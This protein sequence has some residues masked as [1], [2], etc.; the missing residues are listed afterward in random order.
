MLR[1]QH[2]EY[3]LLAF[4][5][6][7][8]EIDKTNQIVELIRSA[9]SVALMPSKTAGVDA[10]AAAGGLYHMLREEG[11]DV[12]VIYPGLPPEEYG[13]VEDLNISPNS[14]KGSL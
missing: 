9:K 11:K 2:L 10:F 12:T 4:K 13:S 8:G 6:M 5:N 14:D 3:I 1:L 7:N